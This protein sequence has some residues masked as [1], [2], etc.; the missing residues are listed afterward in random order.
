MIHLLYEFCLIVNTVVAIAFWCIEGPFMVYRHAI[1]LPPTSAAGAVL[2]TIIGIQH[3]VPFVLVL[4]EWWHNSMIVTSQ[5]LYFYLLIGFAYM[6]M[7]SI[8]KKF[9]YPTAT[10]YHPMDFVNEPL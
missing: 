2:T 5:R 8:L 1:S 10:I 9:V 6:L 7:L 3:I 4:F